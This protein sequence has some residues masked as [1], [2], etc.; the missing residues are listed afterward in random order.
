MLFNVLD[1]KKSELDALRPLPSDLVKNLEEWFRI[2]LTYTSNAIE[3]NTLTRRETALVVEKGITVGGKTLAE[4][5]EAT[6]HAEALDWTKS[7]I[8]RRPSQISFQDT[9]RIHN[10]ILKGVD[11]AHAGHY[12][13]V[14]VRVSG[15]TV[16]FP[17]PR[18]VPDLMD[19][20]HNWLKSKP[21]LHPIE[22]AAEAHYRLVTIHPFVVG[23]GRTARLLMNLILMMQGYPPAIIRKRDRLNYIAILEKAQTFGSKDPFVKLISKAAERSLEIYLK[24]VL[25]KDDSSQTDSD[26]LLKIGELAKRIGVPNSTIRHWTKSG[27]LQVAETTH[28]GYQMY[29]LDMIERIEKIMA[30]KEK[31]LTLEEI[32]K[33]LHE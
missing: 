22:L 2:E 26:I 29:N 24:A 6:N 11:N 3:G 23:N 32:K 16:V 14:P 33:R 5:L 21:K 7:Q 20:L 15:S 27:L 8:K 28:S 18:K 17:N 12:R 10:L 25:Q 13:S 4:H 1:R 19:E 9:L 30:L 31:R